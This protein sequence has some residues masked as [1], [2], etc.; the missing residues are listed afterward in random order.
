MAVA[1]VQKK[2]KKEEDEEEPDLTIWM[3]TFGDLLSLLLTFFVLMFS[4]NSLDDQVLKDML[5]A[6]AGGSGAMMFADMFPMEPPR[7][8]KFIS[9]KTPSVNEFLR[10]LDKQKRKHQKSVDTSSSGLLASLL[11]DGVTIRRRGP[12][13]VISFPVTTMFE[14]GSAKIRRSAT[15]AFDRLAE[16]LHYSES[17]LLIEGHTDDRPI[18]TQRFASNWELSATRASNVMRYFAEKAKMKIPY[19]RLSAIGYANV[20]PVVGNIGEVYRDRNRRVDVVIVQ[21]PEEG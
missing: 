12:M 11:A 18:A 5:S 1:T 21:A 6:F 10:Y 20:R 15:L 3:V 9:A 4:M 19:E 17:R 13:F 16:I 7:M 2:K 14:P 8:E